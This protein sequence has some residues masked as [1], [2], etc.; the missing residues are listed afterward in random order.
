MIKAALIAILGD[1]L[2]SHCIEC[3]RPE[4]LN[5]TVTLDLYPAIT[6]ETSSPL[7]PPSV[8]TSTPVYCCSSWVSAFQIPWDRFPIR[9][10]DAI[11]RG[12]RAHPEDRR[13]M[14]RIVVEA[15]QVHCRNPKRSAC[16]E[17]AKIIAN[18]Y[19]QT[20][21]DFTDKG[22]K[23][24][25]GHYSLLRSIKCRVEHVNRDNVAHRLRQQKR[26]RIEG[27]CISDSPETS[28][29]EVRCLSDRYGCINWQ[30][31][32]LP[33]GE[34]QGSLEDKKNT[35]LS[36][37]HSEGPEAVDRSV[38]NS[39]MGLT[40]ISQRQLINSCPSLLIA[41]IQEQ[42]PFL[43]TLYGMSSHFKQLTGID[44]GE[45]L[46]QALI[47]KGRRILNYFSSQKLKW[48]V[49]IR[50]YILQIEGEGDLS[51]NKVAIAAVVLM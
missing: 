1:N 47:T 7:T 30:P 45:W 23:L 2:G 26:I 33:E 15:M 16:E 3:S 5:D 50:N 37:F 17:I 32:Q 12:E 29:K 35:L 9:L 46:N 42:W 48:N 38:V 28:H 13:S 25:S 10:S 8:S 43:F 6:V 36:I 49:E 4:D 24:G 19:P 20:F 51:N 39:L 41:E 31:V 34:T 44:I 27:D 40:Y 21:A 22:E 18:T 11:T 14:V